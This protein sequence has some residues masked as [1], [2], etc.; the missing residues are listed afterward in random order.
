[1]AELSSKEQVRHLKGWLSTDEGLTA[2]DI[3]KEMYYNV[4]S[5]SDNSLEMARIGGQR[6]LI[7]D[8]IDYSKGD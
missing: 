4:P 6:D 3:L 7:E 2:L 5:Y 1:M 8:L